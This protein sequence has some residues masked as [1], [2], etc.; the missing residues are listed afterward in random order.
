[1]S[2]V[3]RNQ[4]PGNMWIQFPGQP[5]QVGRGH[6]LA[7]AV[8]VEET[9]DAAL[10]GGQVYWSGLA[11]TQWFFSPREDLAAVLMTQRYGG[12]DLPYWT[13]FMSA[14]RRDLRRGR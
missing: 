8:V 14:L 11:G 10:V 13:D 1:M 3:T 7:A 6:S 4:L 12:A 9:P 2:L 5:P